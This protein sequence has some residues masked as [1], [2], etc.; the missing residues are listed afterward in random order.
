[1]IFNE[2]YG[3]YYK[4]L[5]LALESAVTGKLTSAE[6]DEIVKKNAFKESC[7]QITD[8]WKH[9]L[10]DNFQT[11]LKNSPKMPLTTLEKRWMKAL[12]QDKR[13]K[14]FS[15]PEIGLEDVEPLFPAEVFFELNQR[16]DG[17]PFDNPD[18][19]EKFRLILSA[20]KE[21]RKVKVL[22]L[23]SKGEERECVCTPLS[24]EYSQKDDKFRL[25]GV[26]N[27]KCATINLGRIKEC[28]MGDVFTE[29]DMICTPEKDYVIFELKDE[30]NTLER[31]MLQFSELQKE[32]EKIGK[33]RYRVKIT[34]D[35]CDVIEILIRILSFG[36]M[37]KVTEPQ[38]FI[39]EI[40]L[41]LKKQKE[42]NAGK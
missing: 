1:M 10:N 4:V 31:A 17:D 39:D 11:P 26:W 32:A 23:N 2:I 15:P 40:K 34:Y 9:L 33:N 29:G 14:L 22:Y 36:P 35:K 30:R 24:L 12:L 3:N 42:L 18:Y 38:C 5:M 8:S 16:S 19:I 20:I 21:K 13:I 7:L 27:G 25:Q 37:I 41:R 28:S 6:L